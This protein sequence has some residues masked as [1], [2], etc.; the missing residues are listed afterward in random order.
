MAILRRFGMSSGQADE[1]RYALILQD[2]DHLLNS[3]CGYAWFDDRFGIHD[4]AHFTDKKNITIFL[5]EEI[6]RC[7][8]SFSP[9]LEL[10]SISEQ[11]STS[12]TRVSFLIECR[13]RESS[14]KIR[15]YT[16]L[17]ARKWVI[18]Q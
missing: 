10:T 5:I 18:D 14:H 17:G 6:K 12:L 13:L 16:D 9:N 7:V 4:T 8:L 2:L 15:V 1:M 3:K 11:P